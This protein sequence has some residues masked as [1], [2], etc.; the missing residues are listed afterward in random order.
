MKSFVLIFE[1]LFFWSMVFRADSADLSRAHRAV[2]G[3]LGQSCWFCYLRG[4]RLRALPG[5]PAAAIDHPHSTEAFSCVSGEFPGFRFVPVVLCS[6]TENRLLSLLPP[7]RYCFTKIPLILLSRGLSSPS[8]CSLSSSILEALRVSE[9]ALCEAT[10][11]VVSRGDLDLRSW[12]CAG[13]RC[14]S[15]VLGFTAREPSWIWALKPVSKGPSPSPGLEGEMR[16]LK[17]SWGLALFWFVTVS[18]EA[19]PLSICSERSK[20]PG[21]TTPQPSLRRARAG[22]VALFRRL[23]FCAQSLSFLVC[24]LSH[25]CCAADGQLWGSAWQQ[26]PDVQFVSWW[27]AGPQAEAVPGTEARPALAALYEMSRLTGVQMMDGATS[28]SLC[29]CGGCL[30]LWLLF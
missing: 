8:S 24:S 20:R 18:C 26:D 1:Y 3:Q 17:G 27:W 2:P 14:S 9:L 30:E 6:V 23:V 15:I 5:Q 22:P 29:C 19:A 11:W 21:K 10:Y 12:Q 13:A 28:S 16:L 25:G 7:I 4:W